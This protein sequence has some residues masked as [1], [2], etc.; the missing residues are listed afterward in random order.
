[1]VRQ[2]LDDLWI[3]L[4]TNDEDKVRQVVQRDDQVDLL[5]A[6]IKRYLAQLGSLSQDIANSRE[7]INQLTYL[8]ELEN[9]GDIID[10]NLSELVLKK[11]KLGVDFT[12]EGWQ[13]LDDFYKKVAQNLLIADTAFTTRDRV[14]AE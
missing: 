12:P 5:D 11:I 8:T 10:K 7:Q 14:L 2:M 1:I 3:A 13:E 6:H 9:A 4:K